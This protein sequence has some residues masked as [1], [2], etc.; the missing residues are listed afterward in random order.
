MAIDQ[1]ANAAVKREIDRAIAERGEIGVQV[2]AYL[3]GELVIDAWGGIADP[4]SGRPVDGDTLFN[5]FSVA[6]VVRESLGLQAKQ[7]A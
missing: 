7:P 5:V 3:H 1:A 6:K 2:A 4:A